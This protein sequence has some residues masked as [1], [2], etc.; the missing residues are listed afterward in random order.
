[1]DRKLAAVNRTGRS[2]LPKTPRSAHLLGSK[3]E[4]L[5]GKAKRMLKTKLAFVMYAGESRHT[6]NITIWPLTLAK[7]VWYDFGILYFGS[8]VA[9]YQEKVIGVIV[10]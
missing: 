8:M 2:R 9:L 7:E 3:P 4:Y 10:L 1:M 5:R 6:L